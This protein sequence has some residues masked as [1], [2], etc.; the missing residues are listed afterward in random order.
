MLQAP[1]V[2]E[3][4]GE[5][6]RSARENLD[7]LRGG[8]R[9]NGRHRGAQ[10]QAKIDGRRLER[11]LARRNA[12]HIEHVIDE[13]RLHHRALLDRIDR[14]ANFAFG[15]AELQHPRP[16]EDCRHR[17][18]KLVRESGQELI[19]P[20]AGVF[21]RL[22]RGQFV[23]DV[24]EFEDGTGRASVSLQGRERAGNRERRAV[25]AHEKVAVFL[26]RL[27]PLTRIPNRTIVGGMTAFIGRGMQN[28]V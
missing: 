16:A 2:T 6:W 18:A 9:M 23:G 19:L 21:E 4:A 11:H 14:A 27:H 17:R 24:A 15:E 3:H 22:L 10:H 7:T 20:P 28:I 25:L 26:E 8:R 12:R 5:L 13:L 1:L